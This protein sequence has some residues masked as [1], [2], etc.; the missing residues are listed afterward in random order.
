MLS[1]LPT[2]S[3]WWISKDRPT[4]SCHSLNVVSPTCSDDEVGVGVGRAATGGKQRMQHI[5]GYYGRMRCVRS[6]FPPV[7]FSRR[8]CPFFLACTRITSEASLVCARGSPLS[9]LELLPPDPRCSTALSRLS[10]CS[11]WRGEI[12]ANVGRI[13]KGMPGCPVSSEGSCETRR[14]VSYFAKRPMV[15]HI[16][17]DAMD[18]IH[19]DVSANSSRRRK[20]GPSPAP[21]CH[22][23]RE[24]PWFSSGC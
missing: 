21:G 1:S 10:S 19:F 4:C 8:P 3:F 6:G 15:V 2:L 13:S 12:A 11:A 20:T 7:R 5:S 9:H 18:W 23:E 16:L 24:D 17:N 14:A 22:H